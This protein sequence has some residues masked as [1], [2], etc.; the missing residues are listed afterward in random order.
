[1]PILMS[2]NK[3]Y[4][5]KKA[6]IYTPGDPKAEPL[7]AVPCTGI[8]KPSQGANTSDTLARYYTYVYLDL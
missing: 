1:M 4:Y 8:V 2:Y 6:F 5:D 7:G 3:V